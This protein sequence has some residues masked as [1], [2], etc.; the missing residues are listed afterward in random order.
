MEAGHHGVV[1]GLVVPKHA[2]REL[3]LILGF[4]QIP[5]RQITDDTV[6]DLVNGHGIVILLA[7]VKIFL[8]NLSL[9]SNIIN[10][11]I[12]QIVRAL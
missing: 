2:E 7:Q 12:I 3:G 11:E 1:G 5:H 4:V 9:P 10:Y 6:L 8:P